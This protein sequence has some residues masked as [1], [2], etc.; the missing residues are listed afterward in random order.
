MAN[1]NWPFLFF[2]HLQFIKVQSLFSS[3][4]NLLSALFLTLMVFLENNKELRGSVCF[5][6]TWY[7]PKTYIIKDSRLI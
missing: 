4:A 3:L 5:P 7:D 2:K 6:R 1:L